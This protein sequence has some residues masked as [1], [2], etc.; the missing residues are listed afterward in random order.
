LCFIRSVEWGKG[1]SFG[2]EY[3][4][5]AKY[6]YTSYLSASSGPSAQHFIFTDV[7][8]TPEGFSTTLRCISQEYDGYWIGLSP[9]SCLQAKSSP[10]RWDFFDKG[11]YWEWAPRDYDTWVKVTPEEVV[12]GTYNFY[13]RAC[14]PGTGYDHKFEIR[15]F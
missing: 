1:L 12:T 15:T 3:Q 4:N 13:V 9:Q 6:S 10:L 2:Y 14:A 11:G 5:G 7:K 8:G